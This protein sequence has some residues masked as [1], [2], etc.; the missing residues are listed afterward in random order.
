MQ[1][2]AAG[3]ATAAPPAPLSARLAVV[4][5]EPLA[6]LRLHYTTPFWLIQPFGGEEGIGY[7]EGE[8]RIEGE[9]LAGS[10]RWVNH[11]RRRPDGAMLPNTNGLIETDDD[12]QLTLELEGLTLVDE[13]RVGRQLLHV[14]FATADERYTWLNDVFAVAEGVI[15]HD[16]ETDRY[17]MRAPVYRVVHELEPR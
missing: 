15:D 10:V 8:G 17:V 16:A 9:R 7:G 5:L 11:P 2:V 12:A 1:E 3:S 14:S 6:E 4:R 13:H